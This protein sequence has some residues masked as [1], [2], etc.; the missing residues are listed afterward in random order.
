MV[1]HLAGRS[2]GS[3][4][5]FLASGP[6]AHLPR[7]GDMMDTY[8]FLKELLGTCADIYG[9]FCFIKTLINFMSAKKQ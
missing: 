6:S 8:E 3:F 7:G 1:A 9:T 5:R 4:A 2:D